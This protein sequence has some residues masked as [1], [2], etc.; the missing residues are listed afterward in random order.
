MLPIFPT[1]GEET[2]HP[3]VAPTQRNAGTTSFSLSGGTEKGFYYPRPSGWE[4]PTH[5]LYL[6]TVWWAS[7]ATTEGRGTFLRGRKGAGTRGVLGEQPPDAHGV[8]RRR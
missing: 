3:R 4:F 5:L 6:N 1:I 2:S 8:V 7:R